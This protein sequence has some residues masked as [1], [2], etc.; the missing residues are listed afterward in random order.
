MI[1]RLHWE[2]GSQLVCM[3]ALVLSDSS[4][5]INVFSTGIAEAILR[6]FP[7]SIGICT[8]VQ[9]ET[10]FLRG[11]KP[12]A[13]PEPIPLDRLLENNVL[14]LTHVQPGAETARYVDLAVDL[15]DGEAMT[16]A[17]AHHRGYR[18]A[19]DD[20][21]ARRIAAQRLQIPQL[22]RTSDL[23][24]AWSS[25]TTPTAADLRTALARIR[26]I[27]RFEPPSDDPLRPWWKAIL[28]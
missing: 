21:K 26:D 3:G 12:D 15:D 8:A 19:T 25:A 24:Y 20:K 23:L 14:Q 27:A 16:L 6:A 5:L 28:P 18:A 11:D 17:I 13:P 9:A 10:L 1:L 7:D 4:T 2:T 22:L